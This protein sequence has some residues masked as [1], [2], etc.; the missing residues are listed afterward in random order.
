[1]P[2]MGRIPLLLVVILA[3]ACAAPFDSYREARSMAPGDLR[4]TQVTQAV[5][6]NARNLVHAFEGCG[7]Y[8]IYNCLWSTSQGAR[9][10]AVASGE[11]RAWDNREH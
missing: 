1:M 4:C 3:C 10:G 11:G 2:L 8:V 6:R 7:R 5:T 9:C